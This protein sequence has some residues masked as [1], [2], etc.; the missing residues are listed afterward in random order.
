MHQTVVFIPIEKCITS[1]L[2]AKPQPIPNLII[3]VLITTFT[4]DKGQ[5]SEPNI[6]S[7]S[8]D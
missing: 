8:R 4:L 1:T 3:S 6:M 7:I 5:L 2:N